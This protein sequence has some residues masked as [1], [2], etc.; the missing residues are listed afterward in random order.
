M[1]KKRK[2]TEEKIVTV[3]KALYYNTYPHLSAQ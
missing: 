2:I 3:F 1:D